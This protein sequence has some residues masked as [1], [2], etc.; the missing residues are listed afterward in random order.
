MRLLDPRKSILNLMCF[1]L[2]AFI[3]VGVLTLILLAAAM[4]Q[5]VLLTRSLNPFSREAVI[6]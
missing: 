4:N 3:C 5:A 6:Q 2:V 1:G